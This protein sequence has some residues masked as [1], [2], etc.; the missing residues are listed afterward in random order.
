MHY[1]FSF[2]ENRYIL[3]GTVQ[4]AHGLHGEVSIHTLSGQ[5]ENLHAYPAL[6][7]VDKKGNISPKLEAQSFRIHKGKAIIRF[8]LTS[9]RTHA[10]NLVGMGVLLAKTDLP[11]LAED[12]FYW[13]QIVG[14]QV[15]TV[16]GKLL[17]R[18]RSFFW[19]GAQDIVVI[20]GE[21]Q[22]YLV[23]LTSAMITEQNNEEMVIDPPPGLL[24]IN[25]GDEERDADL[26]A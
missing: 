2:P 26:H 18:I 11:V 5:P 1:T 7:L 13:H 22:E 21:D 24:D 16:G 3:I 23:P 10:E 19:N 6:Y 14:L 25:A 4:K 15:R 12:E 17:G 8:D 20:E 9:D